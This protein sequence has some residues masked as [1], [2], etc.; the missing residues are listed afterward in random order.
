MSIEIIKRDETKN[1]WHKK[2][3]Y[4][5]NKLKLIDK[6]CSVY[7]Q[8]FTVLISNITIYHHTYIPIIGRR[9]VAV[10]VGTGFPIEG[11][12]LLWSSLSKVKGY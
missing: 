2:A 6:L 12:W 8:Y 4:Q 11:T 5:I 10:R 7:N 3:W 9:D 1:Q